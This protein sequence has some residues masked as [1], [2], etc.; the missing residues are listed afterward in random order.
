MCRHEWHP[1]E[2]H[3]CHRYSSLANWPPEQLAMMAGCVFGNFL[4]GWLDYK[5]DLAIKQSLDD[6]SQWLVGFVSLP[7]HEQTN[8]WTMAFVL[9]RLDFSEQLPMWTR[10]HWMARF[11]VFGTWFQGWN[12]FRVK[13]GIHAACFIIWSHLDVH[14][15]WSQ[16]SHF[17]QR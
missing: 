11:F 6:H 13:N 10:L 16:M 12:D 17:A 14:R 7:A 9:A 3:D 2:R 1:F 4:F 8:H 15:H 5:A